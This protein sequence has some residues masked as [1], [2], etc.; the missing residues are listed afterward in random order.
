MTPRPVRAGLIGLLA[1][2]ALPPAAAQGAPTL[3]SP[4]A[5]V[6]TSGRR[7]LLVTPEPGGDIA[8]AVVTRLR[9]ELRA[10]R[11]EMDV[12][13]IAADAPR[14]ASVEEMAMRDGTTAALGIFFGAGR[15]EM[16]ATDASAGR[17]LMQNIPLDAG[18]SD[19]RAAI[20]AVK[21]VD[22]LKA[23][24]AEIWTATA[25]ATPA[26]APP[27]PEATISA[28]PTPPPAPAA[29]AVENPP[30]SASTNSNGRFWIAAGG[31][32][33]AAGSVAGWA[34]LLALSAALGGGGLAARLTVSAFG[35]TPTV[36]TTAGS[37]L[38]A[39]QIGLAELL[40]SSRAWHRLRGALA[41]GIGPHHLSI[42][43]RG[44]AGFTGVNYSLWST[45]TTA[46]AGG[47]LDVLPQLV[48][49]LDVRAVENWP[50]TAVNINGAQVARFGRPTVWVALAAGVRFR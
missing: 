13:T 31:G 4:R 17:T 50:A 5:A 12:A 3:E 49:A 24:L 21:A 15:V 29:I 2:L 18:A 48:L 44:A 6:A 25:T 38:L 23:T 47:A 32:W 42:D 22:L 8:P 1:A 9:G 20:V 40:L 37:A 27:T 30:E 33:L 34:P 7:V 41:I 16:W 14:R 10:A 46:G 19:R 28:A 35:Q 43:G 11:F 45:A 36:A 26:P 39:Q